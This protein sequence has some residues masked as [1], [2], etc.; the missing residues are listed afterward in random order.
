MPGKY[1]KRCPH[2]GHIWMVPV[3]RLK[4]NGKHE[5]SKL[6]AASR[7][8]RPFSDLLSTGHLPTWS[9]LHLYRLSCRSCM[10][11]VHFEGKRRKAE[12]D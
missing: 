10:L 11:D 12:K 3:P 8:K 6:T 2:A 7:R 4:E 9:L 1:Q 5:M